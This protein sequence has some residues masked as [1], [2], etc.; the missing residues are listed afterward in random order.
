MKKKKFALKRVALLGLVGSM[1]AL[2][3][4][5]VLGAGAGALVGAAVTR[6]PS[7]AAVG[8]MVGAAVGAAADLETARAR[9][10]RRNA[11][12]REV[13]YVESGPRYAGPRY[14]EA[15]PRV[16]YTERVYHQPRVVY[17]P[18]RRARRVYA[19]RRRWQRRGYGYC[20]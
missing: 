17:A 18:P 2:T 11:R 14:V 15:A 4:C 13:V 9:A 10:Y 7:G 3:G 1:V 16:V 8:A 19:P 12:S 5:T 6:R 20:D